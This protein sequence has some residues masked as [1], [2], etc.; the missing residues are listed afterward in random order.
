LERVRM[1]VL[2]EGWAKGGVVRFTLMYGA[3]SG[4]SAACGIFPQA[5]GRDCPR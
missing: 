2:L 1:F 4:C 5:P 3:I